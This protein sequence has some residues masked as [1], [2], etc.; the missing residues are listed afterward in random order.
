MKPW[1]VIIC[2][3]L[4]VTILILITLLFVPVGGIPSVPVMLQNTGDLPL[5]MTALLRLQAQS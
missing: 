5:A 1:F 3:Y 2:K 4:S